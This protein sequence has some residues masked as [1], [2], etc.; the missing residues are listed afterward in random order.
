MMRE[1]TGR[2]VL[3][4]LI[5]SFGVVFAVNSWFAY[6]AIGSFPGLEADK[7]YRR[8]LAFNDQI[9]RS[10]A[11]N[12]LG[13][14]FAADVDADRNLTLRFTDSTGAALVVS[15]L[16]AHLIH[17]AAAKDDI[18]LKTRTAG[19]GRF[20]ASLAPVTKGQRELRI[21]ATANDGQ[22]IEFRRKIWID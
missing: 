12:D 10:R 16:S 4:I 19:S 20:T 3:T 11:L 5:V 18:V 21:T 2:H 22:T 14:Q 15:N 17:P 7:A 9:A 6:M 13:W 8:G 1:L